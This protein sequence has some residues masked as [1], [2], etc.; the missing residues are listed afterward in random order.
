MSDIGDGIAAA[1]KIM[2]IVAIL[3]TVVVTASVIYLVV[4]WAAPA[5]PVAP[6][7]EVPE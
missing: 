3:V 7:T 4:R 6:V 2:F 5:P 1:F